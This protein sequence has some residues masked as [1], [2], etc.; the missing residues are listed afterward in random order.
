MDLA[1]PALAE[2]TTSDP[3][4][5]GLAFWKASFYS[6]ASAISSLTRSCYLRRASIVNPESSAVAASAALSVLAGDLY[7]GF[8]AVM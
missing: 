3:P 1:L 2:F 4:A 6:L 8:S 5:A 7:F